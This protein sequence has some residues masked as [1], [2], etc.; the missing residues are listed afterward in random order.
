[1]TP[2]Q[3]S[4]YFDPNSP[5]KGPDHAVITPR[6]TFDSSLSASQVT[7]TADEVGEAKP[8]VHDTEAEEEHNRGI[9]FVDMNS[10]LSRQ[11][12]NTFFGIYYCMTGL[13]GVHVIVGM[14]LIYWI[15]WRAANTRQRVWIPPLPILAIGAYMEFIY[16]ISHN[17][18]F[19]ITGIP[20]LVIGAGWMA[21]R[22]L[23]APKTGVVEDGE[24][25]SGYFA[26]VDLIGL[27]WHIVDLIWI[28]LFPLLYL[29]HGKVGS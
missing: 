22:I 24:F 16:A 18:Y 14:S 2:A 17:N 9:E 12:I 28:F 10:N 15:M 25:N 8:T 26:P 21:L 3:P 20:F 19:L 27:Y 4:L 7:H 5:N 1:M 6:Y 23:M 29:I 11:R 13:H